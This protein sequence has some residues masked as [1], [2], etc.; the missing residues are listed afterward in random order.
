MPAEQRYEGN[1]FIRDG[2]ATL[3]PRPAVVMPRPDTANFTV[4]RKGV[5]NAPLPATYTIRCHRMRRTSFSARERR[6]EPM[7]SA[8]ESNFGLTS[9]V[10][11]DI[12][13]T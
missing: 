2:W 8:V 12:T 1:R 9:D 13:A 7:R 3:P 11:G 4:T 10:S 5:K 6:S